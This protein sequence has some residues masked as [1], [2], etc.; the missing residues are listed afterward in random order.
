MMD[1]KYNNEYNDEK[2][3][4]VYSWPHI[5]QEYEKILKEGN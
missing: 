3:T 5:Y 4:R 2:I 1:T